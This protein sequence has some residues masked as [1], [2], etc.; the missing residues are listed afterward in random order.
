MFQTKISTDI[1]RAAALLRQGEVV[2][3]PTETVYGLAGNALDDQAVVKIF[4]AK[5]RPT[6]NPLIVHT[7]SVE[8]IRT[9]VQEIPPLGERLIE[10]FMPGPLTLLLPKSDKIP[11]LV[12]AGSGKVAIR[13]PNH[14]LTLALLRS[15]DFPL[16]APSANPSGYISPTTA[17]HVFDQ[18]QGKIP[19]ILDGGTCQVGL[20]STIVGWNEAGEALVY[21]VGGLSVEKLEEVCGQKLPILT[22]HEAK[23]PQTAGQ[24]LSHYAPETPLMLGKPELLLS[25]YGREKAACLTFDSLI[26]DFPEAQQRVLAPDGNY[27]TAARNLFAFLRDLD[28]GN[29]RIIYAEELPEEGLGR[30]INDRLRRARF[31]NKLLGK[32]GGEAWE[33]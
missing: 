29:Y 15:L 16:A 21:R 27:A 10:A 4:E 22:H 33:E 11:D 28:A 23:S 5:N 8:Q 32:A 1:A 2:A 14:P 9:F 18:L 25:T 13:M 31:E 20:E 7:G 6:F 12:T 3:I 26:G 19:Y 30:A 24:L 17:Q